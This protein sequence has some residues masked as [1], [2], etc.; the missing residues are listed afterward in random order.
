MSYR[1]PGD[2]RHGVSHQRGVPVLDAQLDRL[3]VALFTA[4]EQVDAWEVGWR[5][6]SCSTRHVTPPAIVQ[7]FNA[8][9]T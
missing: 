1:E 5:S 7:A 3:A 8:P 4:A 9:R 6:L 2:A